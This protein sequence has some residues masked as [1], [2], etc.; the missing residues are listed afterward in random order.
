MKSSTKNLVLA[1]EI[2]AREIQSNQGIAN[3][4]IAEAAQ[5]LTQFVWIPTTDHFPSNPSP[6][7]QES[8]PCLAIYKNTCLILQWNPNVSVWDDEQGSDYFCLPLDVTH[9]I[10][11]P[12]P[13]P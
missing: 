3:A 13:P 6:L 2:L 7:N 8:I 12:S 4:C 1:L 9:W 11:L 5:R 10:N